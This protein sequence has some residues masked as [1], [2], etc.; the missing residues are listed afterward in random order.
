VISA[1][2]SSPPPRRGTLI[3]PYAAAVKPLD[4]AGLDFFGSA[5]L[6]ITASA[7]LN[8]SPERL[9]AS[10][11]DASQWLRWWPMM[12]TCKWT[13][14]TAAVGA[15]REVVVRLLG[16][17]RERMIAWQPGQRFAFTMIASTSP[18]ASQ[19]AEDYRLSADGT[20]T[21][22][23]WTL[24]ARPRILGKLAAPVMRVTMLRMFSSGIVNLDRLLSAN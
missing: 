1:R 11:A 20:G 14:D 7:R 18:M 16:R 13:V 10:F 5:P 8:A 4:A 12:T 22:L 21:R 2:I 3:L 6:Q 17:F 23:D 24:A 9:F 19:L 15:E